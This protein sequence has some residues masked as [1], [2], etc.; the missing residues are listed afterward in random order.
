MGQWA[1]VSADLLAS[2]GNYVIVMD[3]VY[4]NAPEEIYLLVEEDG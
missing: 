4:N 3:G 2:R 1:A